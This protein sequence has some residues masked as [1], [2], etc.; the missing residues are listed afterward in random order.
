MITI[1]IDLSKVFDSISHEIVLQKL[2]SLGF[3]QRAISSIKGYL[4]NRTQKVVLQNT[5]LTDWIDSYQGGP[6]CTVLG[7]LLFILYVNSIQNAIQKPC[8][9]VQYA[10]D[11]F[12][13][14]SNECLKTAMSQL[15]TN[16]ANLV[17]YFEWQRLNL[18]ESKTEFIV[19]C[20]R[21]KNSS[22]KNLKFR[23]TIHLRKHSSFVKYLGIYFDQ[24]L[25][26]E[27]KVKN[28]LLKM[29]C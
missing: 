16:C 15:E 25:T 28:V 1:K 9:L 18:I 17:V 23:L 7:P 21:S 14:V 26:Y 27:Y 2:E 24:S 4:S 22:T 20:K 3:D 8:E 6:H 13:F 10:D 19:F 11:T 12:L 29:A 5:T